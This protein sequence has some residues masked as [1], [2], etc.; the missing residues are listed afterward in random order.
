M[1]DVGRARD[2][3][4]R[5]IDAAD[6][7][8]LVRH[9]DRVVDLARDDAAAWA[10]LL[11]LAEWCRAA[12]ERGRQLWPA[13][14]HAHHRV[15]L[16]APGEQAVRALAASPGRFGL[17]PLTEVVA[18]NHAWIELAPALRRE[19][20]TGPVALTVAH[21]R[22]VR[23]EDLR[24]ERFVLG[25][26]PELPLALE[27]WEPAYPIVTYRAF[28]VEGGEPPVVAPG[29]PVTLGPAPTS[30]A[31]TAVGRAWRDAFDHWA[32]ASAGRVRSVEVEGGPLEALAALTGVSAPR[33]AP[34]DAATGLGLIA[35]GAASGGTHGRRRGAAAGRDDTWYV[36]ARLAGLD[37]PV[38]PAALGDAVAELDWFVWH[39]DAAAVG[40][41]AIRL[42]VHDP[43]DALAWALEAIDA[44]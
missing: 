36:A 38:D 35:A 19:L 23:G 21:E 6:V 34:I 44:G 2:E 40:G 14:D 17:G 28:D 26:G 15:A 22:V 1:S 25:A 7:E 37:W 8:E 42:V 4:R 29:A 16:G 20:G 10:H 12:A 32:R 41:W 5:L 3:T 33:L 43:H 11:E 30:R 24:G 9:V 13:A 18:S 27:P 31:D 39:D